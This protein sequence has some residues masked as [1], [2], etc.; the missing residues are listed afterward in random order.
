M[1]CMMV[2]KGLYRLL[3]K[4]REGWNGSL[5]QDIMMRDED[6]EGDGLVVR[7]RELGNNWYQSCRGVLYHLFVIPVTVHHGHVTVRYCS[8]ALLEPVF[9]WCH[10]SYLLRQKDGEHAALC[11]DYREL[12]LRVMERQDISKDCFSYALGHY[13]FLYLD[14]SF[15]V[16]RERHPRLLQVLKEELMSGTLRMVGIIMDP[17]RL[18]LSPNGRDPLLRLRKCEKFSGLAGYYRRFVEG[19]SRLALPLTSIDGERVCA[20]QEAQKGTHDRL[21]VP[22]DQALREK[23]M[24]EAHSY[25]F[26]IHPGQKLNIRGLVGLL[27]AVG[28][29][30]YHSLCGNGDEI[31]MDFV[32]GLPTTQKDMMRIWVMVVD[33]TRL[34]CMYTDFYCLRQRS[35][36]R[37]TIQTLKDML[38]LVALD[39]GQIDLHYFNVES[40]L[41]ESLLN[42]DIL[43]DSSPKFDYLLE[44]F[45][46]E[47]VHIDPI[48]P[49]VEICFHFKPDTGVVTNK[50]VGDISEY[51]VLMPNLLPTHPTFDPDLDF[52]PSHDSLR[53]G[54]KIFDPGIF[55]EVQ[56]ERLLSWD[57]FSISFIH[58]PF[59]LLFD[60]LLSFLS[61]NEDKVFNPGILISPLLSH[62]GHS[63][64]EDSLEESPRA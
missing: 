64:C 19:F 21:C 55:I 53:S 42:H 20:N 3:E 18:K 16:H 54:N 46:G 7:F 48:P 12:N 6:A 58:D 50:V 39:S 13:E 8:L 33:R 31:S 63:F 26:T 36:F 40:N 25:P 38:V 23:V 10:R 2:V 30:L 32:T 17:Q 34:D 9:Q 43:I 56:S 37:E 44:E 22:N 62:Q 49:D 61:E 57:E 28:D 14:S 51:N 29:F 1:D 5:K 59:S 4:W 35:D 41:I 45:S 11:I 60:T 27:L 15:C 47:L 52:T 24:T